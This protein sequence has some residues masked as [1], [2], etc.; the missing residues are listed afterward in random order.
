MESEMPEEVYVEI[1]LNEF[2]DAMNKIIPLW[3]EAF[4]D[5]HKDD[6]EMSKDDDGDSSPQH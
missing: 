6:E 1:N 3:F 2:F 5:A 4:I